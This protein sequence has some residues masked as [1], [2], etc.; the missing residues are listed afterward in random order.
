MA[1]T[2]QD[3]LGFGWVH[4][5]FIVRKLWGYVGCHFWLTLL[6]TPIE[7][8]QSPDGYTVTCFF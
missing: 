2:Q 3:E 8:V 4:H 5:G 6:N 1:F 7:A